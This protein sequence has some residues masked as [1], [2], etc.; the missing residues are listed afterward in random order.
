MPSDADQATGPGP[1][2]AGPA[3]ARAIEAAGGA[4][5]FDDFLDVALYGADGFYTHV[6]RAGR[7][8]DFLTSPE[9]GPLYGAVLA[10][11]IDAEFERLG[12]PDDFRVIE[13]GAGPGTLARS[14]LARWRALGRPQA[15]PYVA[16][17]TSAA[18]RAAHPPEVTS[19]AV[20]PEG[21]ITGVVLAN[22]L[23]DNLPFRLLVFDGGWRE[24]HVT[25]S[26][27]RLL[28]VL[29][30]VSE[31]PPWL[32]TTAPHG[33]R[34]PWQAA[35][36]AWVDDTLGRLAAGRLLCVDYVTARTGEL[37]GAPWRSWLRTYR[38]HERGVHY[39]QAVGRQ[40][41]TSQVALDQLPEPTVVR[42]QEQFLR[43]WGI[44]ELV[45]EGR[46]AWEA[47]AA[48]PTVAAMAMRSRVREAEA[49]LDPA[50]LGAFLALEWER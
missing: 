11:W 16:V 2:D 29:L 41:V 5:R 43:R 35:A 14:I 6:G 3:V 47:A 33:A 27:G 31:A 45:D 24:A 44:D 22:E 4:L 12:G 25:V 39:L 50:G 40:D 13:V 48:A 42:T 9:V 26:G 20:V 15:H 36:G 37:A 32:P 23:L 34:V 17:E 38:G 10:A 1:G 19:A 30:P 18:Q 28:E 8:G 46:R 21:P 49:L 7:R